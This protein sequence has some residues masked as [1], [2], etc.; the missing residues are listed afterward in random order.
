MGH[1]LKLG[2]TL[3]VGICALVLTF[4]FNLPEVTR[5]LVTVAGGLLALSM[6]WEMVQTLKSGRYG[7]DLLA[8]MPLWPR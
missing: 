2:A 3:L 4:A 8:I 5:L 1:R 7:I 6:V